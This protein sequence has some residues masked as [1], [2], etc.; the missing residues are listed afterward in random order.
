MKRILVSA[1]LPL[2]LLGCTNEVPN[3]EG[4]C[5]GLVTLS[6]T[7]P[8]GVNSARALDLTAIGPEGARYTQSETPPLPQTSVVLKIRE[9]YKPGAYHFRA[10]AA[11]GDPQKGAAASPSAITSVGRISSTLREACP[12]EQVTLTAT[13]MLDICFDRC[14]ADLRCGK[15]SFAEFPTCQGRC[16]QDADVF[17]Q[18]QADWMKQYA[19][20]VDTIQRLDGCTYVACSAIEDCG[21]A[22]MKGLVPKP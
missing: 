19:N 7:A 3:T 12:S 20:A 22:L 18:Q 14:D 15:I 13:S 10:A 1:L 9:A 17:A 6:L 16:R 4:N 5:Q 11:D 8:G 21:A 2:C